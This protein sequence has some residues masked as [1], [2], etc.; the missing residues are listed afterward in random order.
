MQC[1]WQGSPSSPSWVFPCLP[2]NPLQMPL[3]G[4]S[5]WHPLWGPFPSSIS[6]DPRSSGRTVL[7]SQPSVSLS[8]LQHPSVTESTAWTHDLTKSLR[9]TNPASAMNLSAHG[10]P[11]HTFSGFREQLSPICSV[12]LLSSSAAMR[13]V[14]FLRAEP[15]CGLQQSPNLLPFPCVLQTPSS[16]LQGPRGC[17]LDM[18][19]NISDTVK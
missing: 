15:W 6:K 7:H 18:E 2:I 10:G 8:P 4:L 9:K 12:L 11:K 13:G 16:S 14:H 19:T 17:I 1:H 5:Q 3:C